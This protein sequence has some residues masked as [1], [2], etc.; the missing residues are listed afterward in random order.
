MYSI[1]THTGNIPTKSIKAKKN[2][3]YLLCCRVTFSQSFAFGWMS[4]FGQNPNFGQQLR[5]FRSKFN[6]MFPIFGM[7]DV[8]SDMP[9]PYNIDED[10]N[11][12]NSQQ[13]DAEK[14]CTPCVCECPPCNPYAA[15]AS[16]ESVAPSKQV[17]SSEQIESL[18]QDEPMGEIVQFEPVKEIQHGKPLQQAETFRQVEY[19]Q[20]EQVGYSQPTQVESYQHV[21][22]SQPEQVEPFRQV[23]YT[24]QVAP[25]PR[26]DNP[27][28]YDYNKRSD[29]FDQFEQSSQPLSYAQSPPPQQFNLR[30]WFAGRTGSPGSSGSSGS[31]GSPGSSGSSNDAEIK[32]FNNG[33]YGIT[34][35]TSDATASYTITNTDGHTLKIMEKI[36]NSAERE[37]TPT[38]ENGVYDLYDIT[39]KQTYA[40][41]LKSE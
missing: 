32:E 12:Q 35:T 10:Q 8:F 1:K 26:V 41:A 27:Q 4:S 21:G 31:S 28:E 14:Q 6:S 30:N 37:F 24:Q 20:P 25:I 2:P 40:F 23:E 33:N 22:Y 11:D 16:F 3:I 7:S 5:G 15:H 19:S 29:N 9:D 39:K 38:I 36:G 17:A 34:G 18:A 13:F